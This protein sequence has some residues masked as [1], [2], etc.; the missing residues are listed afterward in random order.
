MNTALR[1][2]G[3]GLA[4][5]GK[6]RARQS[7]FIVAKLF[8]GGKLVFPVRVLVDGEYYA[9]YNQGTLD[10]LE[11]GATPAWLKLEP[12]EPADEPVEYPEDDRRAS[13]ADRSHQ[14]AKEQF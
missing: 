3:R 14:F 7:V 9:V 13:A 5:L 6:P 8:S 4:L 10:A 2:T 1:T 12:W 11:G